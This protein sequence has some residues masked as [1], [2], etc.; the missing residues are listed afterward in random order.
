MRYQWDAGK[1]AA[2]SAVDLLGQLLKGDALSKREGAAARANE[3]GKVGTAAQAFAEVVGQGTD[4]GAFAALNGEHEVRRLPAVDSQL[5]NDDWARL[6]HDLFACSHPF[7]G[8]LPLKL[9]GGVARWH[10]HLLAKKM[11]AMLL[12]LRQRELRG[13]RCAHNA[14]LGI[15]GIRDGAE[16][17]VCAIGFAA[18]AQVFRHACPLADADG[19]HTAGKRVER[20]GM[21][22]PLL[23]E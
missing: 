15:V 2:F 14:S 11:R 8:W 6:Q 10:L 5:G 7:I 16:D 9:D 20:A 23:L 18:L 12:N 22:N 4:V 1:L 19:Q 13:V 3:R 21:P 17:D